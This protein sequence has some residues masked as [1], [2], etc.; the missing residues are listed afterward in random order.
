MMA[1]SRPRVKVPKKA[2]K[3]DV[4]TIKTLI[5]HRME[6]GHRK[7][8]KTG[9][10]VPRKIINKFECTFNGAPVF[11]CDLEPAIAANPYLKFTAKVKASG[12]FIFKWIDDDKSV[13]TK[14]A[15]IR[16]V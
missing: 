14:N 7:D 8:T 16:V 12:E 1:R 6:S 3:G 15:K 4:I 9:N 2:G 5:T 10:R 13:Y 11:K